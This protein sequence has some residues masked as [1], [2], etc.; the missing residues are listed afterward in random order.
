[1]IYIQPLYIQNNKINNIKSC[2][3]YKLVHNY[4]QKK[5]INLGIHWY[6]VKHKLMEQYF[7]Y[8]TDKTWIF[9]KSLSSKAHVVIDPGNFVKL[10]CKT[11]YS[12]ILNYVHS[13]R[14][15]RT[16]VMLIDN[17]WV[18]FKTTKCWSIVELIAYR[19]AHIYSFVTSADWQLIPKKICI[20]G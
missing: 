17:S 10:L 12:L 7:W 8:N 19:S 20:I 2:I 15:H 11:I 5:I 1:M 3:L 6:K 14:Q 13:N 9:Y 18:I 16:M 4:L